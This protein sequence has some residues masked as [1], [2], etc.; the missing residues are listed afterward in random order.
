MLR[1][2]DANNAN[3]TLE[4]QNIS[5]IFAEYPMQE[6]KRHLEP[7]KLINTYRKKKLSYYC[8]TKDKVPEYFKS[9]IV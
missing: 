3:D 8:N 5:T 2:N 4:Q 7:F 9:R 1:N 6:Y